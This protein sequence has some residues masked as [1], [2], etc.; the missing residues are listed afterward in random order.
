VDV[1]CRSQGTLLFVY[2]PAI[3]FEAGADLHSPSRVI[4][5]T[6][7]CNWRA[8]VAYAVGA[9]VNFAGCKSKGFLRLSA[10]LKLHPSAVLDNMGY[11]HFS[12]GV[13][14]SFYFAFIT[15]GL[16]AGLTYYIL[17]RA[18]PQ[19]NFLIHKGMK[20]EEWTQDQVEMYAAGKRHDLNVHSELQVPEYSGQVTPLDEEKRKDG[21]IVNVLNVDGEADDDLTDKRY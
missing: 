14:R 21:A 8:F 13:I 12:I 18:F 3:H 15:T 17:A 5:Y 2:V 11:H 10:I 6:Y 9:G 1:H 7:G 16:A 4:V 20:F 19:P